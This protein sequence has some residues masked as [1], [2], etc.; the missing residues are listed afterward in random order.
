MFQMLKQ[1]RLCPS[2]QSVTVRAF[3]RQ[4][5]GNASFFHV[6]LQGFSSRV[7][8]SGKKLSVRIIKRGGGKKTLQNLNKISS[9]QAQHMCIFEFNVSVL[10]IRKKISPIKS[11]L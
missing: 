1:N 11:S 7:Q 4:I 9:A 2:K 3:N 8:S 10:K 5:R 6:N